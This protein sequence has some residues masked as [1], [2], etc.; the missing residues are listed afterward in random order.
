MAEAK[1]KQI[2]E[3]DNKGFQV[4]IVRNKKEYSRYFS[5]QVWGGKRK[6]LSSAISWRDQMLIVFRERNKYRP[7]ATIPS[8]KKS[9]GVTG[10]IKTVQ[11]DKRRDVYYLVYSCLWYQNGNRHTKTFHVGRADKVSPDEEL[12]AFRT[13]VLF[14]KEYEMFKD[15]GME[16]RF[17]SDR[18][19]LWK[20]ERLYGQLNS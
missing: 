5:H 10:V 14:R 15:E 12:H 4:R 11:F 7:D 2:T 8:N 20:K 1:Y 19:K 18:Y 16:D 6:S 3:P 13:A 17:S 9:T